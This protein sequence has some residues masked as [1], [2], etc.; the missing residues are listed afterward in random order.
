MG[1]VLGVDCGAV[2]SHRSA[3]WLHELPGFHPEP[4]EVTLPRG[5]RSELDP[6]LR[7]HRSNCMPDSHRTLIDH[8]P[9]STLARVLL[10]L[11]AVVS[12]G[13]V[14]RTMDTAIAQGRVAYPELIGVLHDVQARGRRRTQIFRVLLEER[15]GL[16]I[17]PASELE[18]RF[19]DLVGSVGIG[20]WHRQVDLGSTDHWIGR[21][22][23]YRRDARLIVEVDG[24]A[25]HSSFL[26]RKADQA[27]QTALEAAGFRV[28]RFGWAEVVGRPADVL[29]TL[30]ATIAALPD[31]GTVA[32]SLVSETVPKSGGGMV[33]PSA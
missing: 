31:F 5:R 14:A 17:P 12:I 25:A 2:I 7:I 23:F 28:L 26:D 29:R 22:D 8:I 27:R 30:R 19:K 3:A 15:Q 1:A 21:V 6:E 10:E 20:T 11:T 13:R 9:V 18:R 32:E 24:K 33:T 16:Y 4:I